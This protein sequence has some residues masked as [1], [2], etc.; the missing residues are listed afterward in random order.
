MNRNRSP[1]PPIAS[2]VQN[3]DSPGTIVAKLTGA[4][5][6]SKRRF[7]HEL[8]AIVGPCKDEEQACT[9]QELW[10]FRSRAVGPRVARAQMVARRFDLNC[11]IN[12]EPIFCLKHY[13]VFYRDDKEV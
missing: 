12:P 6:D 8:V 7:V 4:T 11:W 9:V 2:L 1:V 13:S 10:S 3:N 5:P